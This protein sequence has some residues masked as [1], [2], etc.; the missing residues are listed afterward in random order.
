MKKALLIDVSAVMY[1]FYYKLANMKNGKGEP[2]GALYGLMTTALSLKEKLEPQYIIFCF[3]TKKESLKRREISKEY[4]ANRSGAPEDLVS[5]MKRVDEVFAPFK[6]KM[7]EKEGY[8]ADDILATMSKKFVM[9]SVETYVF[10]GDKDLMQLVDNGVKIVTFSK[11]EGPFDIIESP[12]KVKEILGV[13]PEQIV[14]LFGIQGDSS[15]NIP[16]VKGVGPKGAI[17][18]IEEYG[19]LEQIYE[20]IENISGSTREK[21]MASKKEAFISKQLATLADVPID[22]DIELMKLESF[23]GEGV[24]QVLR[25]LEFKSILK[26]LKLED[27]SPVEEIK[28]KTISLD[29]LNKIEGVSS[30]AID[31]ERVAISTEKDNFLLEEKVENLKLNIPF[32]S[33]NIKKVIKRNNLQFDFDTKIA[34]HLLNTEEIPKMERMCQLL[35][36]RDYEKLIGDPLVVESY[37]NLLFK[38]ILSNQIKKEGLENVLA[39]EIR[40]APIIAKMENDGVKIDVEYLKKYETEMDTKIEKLEGEIYE[41]IGQKFNLASPKQLSKVLFQDMC[42]TPIKKIKTGFSTDNEV[43]ASL[44]RKGIHVAG[45]ILEHRKLT[46]LNSTYIKALPKL[47]DEKGRVHSTFDQD[48]AATGRFSSTNP[49]LQNIPSRTPE[50]RLIRRAFV[51]EAGSS[52]MVAD[53]SQI[54]LRILASLSKDGNLLDA[55][56]RGLDLHSITASIIFKKEIDQIS[57][58]EREKAKVV[59]FSLIYGKSPF[60][61]AKEIQISINDAKEYIERY[62]EKYSKVKDFI[63]QTIKEA[64]EQGYVKTMFGRIRRLAGINSRNKMLKAASQ[65]MA[66]NTIIQGTQAEIIKKAMIAIDEKIRDSK[67]IRLISQVHDE[68][69]FEVSDS[70]IGK[71][72]EIISQIM[73]KCVK[74]P[75]VNLE[76]NVSCAKNWEEA[77]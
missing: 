4:K 47:C 62:F 51:A 72:K 55:Y 33:F 11:G 42:I 1:R 20:N 76:V 7:L 75:D 58:S 15:D 77:K 43:L 32:T 13:L 17:K 9:A 25:D 52:L 65:R 45:L 40:L 54:E 49:N 73:E 39:N 29:D 70:K 48:G 67:D 16:G 63:D 6:F 5:Q 60:G 64:E 59:N 30:I 41:E 18:L 36:N 24:S 21:L 37:L 66:V 3:D 28:H 27:I 8:E 68:L 57:R 56:N 53:Y 50:G 35:L 38:K 23:D 26:K 31:D 74:I 10:T 19:T 61:L 2:T 34:Q 12:D 69:I 46:K 71:Y 22:E 44:E 14:D